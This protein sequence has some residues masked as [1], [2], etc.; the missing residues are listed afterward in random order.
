MKHESSYSNLLK[1]NVK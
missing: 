1:V